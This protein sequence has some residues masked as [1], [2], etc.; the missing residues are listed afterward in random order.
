MPNEWGVMNMVLMQRR[1]QKEFSGNTEI[2]SI[3]EEK[4][5]N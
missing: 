3:Q 1:W 2:M 4:V 5:E